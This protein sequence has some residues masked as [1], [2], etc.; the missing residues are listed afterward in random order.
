[1]DDGHCCGARVAG[2]ASDP[3]GVAGMLVMVTVL[4][5]RVE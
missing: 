4:A 5:R 2:P 1:M 3:G